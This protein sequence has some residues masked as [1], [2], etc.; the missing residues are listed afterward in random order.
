MEVL[1]SVRTVLAVRSYQDKPVRQ[2]SSPGSSRPAC[3]ASS[4]MAS[5]GTLSSSRTPTCCAAWLSPR[6]RPVIAEARWRRRGDRKD[7]TRSPMVV[8]PSNR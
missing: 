6:N 5:P 4:V 8:A 7:A 1:D 2:N 3:E